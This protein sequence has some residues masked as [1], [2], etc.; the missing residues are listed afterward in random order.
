MH[1]LI[2]LTCNLVLVHTLKVLMSQVLLT[3]KKIASTAD[4][5]TSMDR[6]IDHD[7]G[8]LDGFISFI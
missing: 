6:L 8:G 2:Q 5:V 1:K 4:S 3:T 7:F